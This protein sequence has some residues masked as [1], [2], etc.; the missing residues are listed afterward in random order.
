MRPTIP[1]CTLLKPWLPWTDNRRVDVYKSSKD[2]VLV[3]LCGQEVGRA[4]VLR[5]CILLLGLCQ[6]SCLQLLVLGSGIPLLLVGNL[7][8]PVKLLPVQLVE[9][10][11]DISSTSAQRRTS[12]R[13]I[14]Y[15]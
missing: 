14:T 5:P 11:V 12:E 10:R 6:L 13:D 7:L 1:K 15:T 4:L 9:L 2:D 3:L 8:Q